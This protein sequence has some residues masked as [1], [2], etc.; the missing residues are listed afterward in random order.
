METKEQADMFGGEKQMLRDKFFTEA[1]QTK[2]T[3][4]PVCDRFGK[5]YPRRH[6]SSMAVG[7]IWLYQ[8]H[9]IEPGAYVNVGSKAPRAILKNGGSYA[10]NHWWG[11]VEAEENVDTK[12]HTSGS[13]RITGKGIAFVQDEIVIPSHVLT[14]DAEVIDCRDTTTD[15]STSLGRPFNYREL[16]RTPLSVVSG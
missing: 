15:I 14:Y 5:I 2:G 9:L 16:M 6:N 12:K 4:C 11:L 1:G 7:L 3:H 10:S 13:W 8:Q